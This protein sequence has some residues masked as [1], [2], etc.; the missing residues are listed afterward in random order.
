MFTAGSSPRESRCCRSTPGRAAHTGSGTRSL[1]SSR[2]SRCPATR[3]GD[4][5]VGLLR[6]ARVGVLP[7]RLVLAADFDSGHGARADIG[8]EHEAVVR[9]HIV[10]DAQRV[11]AGAF[12]YREVAG[13]RCQ[14]LVGS[15]ERNR[16]RGTAAACRK[17]GETREQP[18]VK[19]APGRTA[20]LRALPARRG[21]GKVAYCP[22]LGMPGT[23][24]VRRQ[25]G[26]DAVRKPTGP[27]RKADEPMG[28]AV[29]RSSK[30]MRSKLLWPMLENPVSCR[31]VIS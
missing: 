21:A 22:T 14:S 12:E 28:S 19:P 8:A 16:R 31:R 29:L 1:C 2:S 27:C 11:N 5:A 7:E 10:I 25:I 20:R 4:V 26:R 13:L 23:R 9:I 30:G 3:S 18:P 17:A 24:F 6:S 15:W